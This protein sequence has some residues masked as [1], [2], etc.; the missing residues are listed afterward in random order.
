[1]GVLSRMSPGLTPVIPVMD[2]MVTVP[3]YWLNGW[4]D[5]SKTALWKFQVATDGRHFKTQ[6]WL[7]LAFEFCVA[8][9]Y[10]L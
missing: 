5:N 6:L 4:M 8:L 7:K 3:L 1:M 9:H 10:S 2:V